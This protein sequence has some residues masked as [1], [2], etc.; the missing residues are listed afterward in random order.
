V[1]RHDKIS[2]RFSWRHNPRVCIPGYLIVHGVNRLV[3]ATIGQIGLVGPAALKR[4]E[5]LADKLDDTDQTPVKSLARGIVF[6]LIEAPAYE[7]EPE[8]ALDP[9]EAFSVDPASALMGPETEDY[10]LF[11]EKLRRLFSET[12]PTHQEKT[13]QGCD[14][15][16]PGNS[17]E[18][19]QTEPQ[20]PIGTGQGCPNTETSLFSSLDAPGNSKAG[21]AKSGIGRSHE[22][23]QHG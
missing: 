3:A 23:D 18:A 17:P 20:S 4:L 19:H 8:E 22:E 6:W 1:R 2:A 16:R 21:I 14:A 10:W 9:L 7:P 12:S 11:R 5:P 13:R 15:H